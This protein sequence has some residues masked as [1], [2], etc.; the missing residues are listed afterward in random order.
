MN[1]PSKKYF[2]YMQ[3]CV[4]SLTMLSLGCSQEY[5]PEYNNEDLAVEN[6]ENLNFFQRLFS[7][8]RPE[9][10]AGY[11]PEGE[12][13]DHFRSKTVDEVNAWET[14]EKLRRAQDEVK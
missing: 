13:V 14:S 1:L 4:F 3:L 5:N 7:H 8:P 11:V 9:R 2:R 12:Y 6:G 10:D